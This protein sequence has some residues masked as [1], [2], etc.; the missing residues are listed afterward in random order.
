VRKA[1][2]DVLN[3]V[4]YGDA[5]VVI[6]RR[7]RMLCA[8]VPVGDLRRLRGLPPE[9]DPIEEANRFWEEGKRALEEKVQR[10]AEERA[11]AAEQDDAA[12]N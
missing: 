2:A 5:R 4:A 3:T 8:V 12:G 6:A 9:P 1:F 10:L 7:G 11:R